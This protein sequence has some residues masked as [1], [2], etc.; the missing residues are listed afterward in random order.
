M[1]PQG[2]TRTFAALQDA[3]WTRRTADPAD[4]RQSLLTITAAGTQALA[5]EM[6][7]R[8]VWVAEAM[9]THLTGPER[10]LLVAAAALLERLAEVDADVAPREQ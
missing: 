1:Q 9:R 6:R 8:D 3:G 5:A 10:A 2:L 4:G 7:P